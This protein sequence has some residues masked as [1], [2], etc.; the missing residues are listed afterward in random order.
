[1]A[2]RTKSLIKPSEPSPPHDLNEAVVVV[3]LE[4]ADQGDPEPLAQ[5]LESTHPLSPLSR[6]Y[7]DNLILR[8]NNAP[9]MHKAVS[10]MLRPLRGMLR[11]MLRPDRDLTVEE[12]RTLANAFRVGIPRPNHPP[13]TVAYSKTV[14][15]MMFLLARDRMSIYGREKDKLKKWLATKKKSGG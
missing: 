1:M 4:K 6:Y 14:S 2:R 7:L 11:S 5:L 12:R 13:P 3:A 9:K 15:E 10:G 8:G